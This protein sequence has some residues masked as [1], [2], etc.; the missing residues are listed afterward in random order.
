VSAISL[1]GTDFQAYNNTY[2]AATGFAGVEG[3]NGSTVYLDPQ[4]AA[5]NPLPPQSITYNV[6]V[7]NGGDVTTV[8]PA[9]T[10]NGSGSITLNYAN[11][12]VSA[13][14]INEIYD[15]SSKTYT[16]TVP[17]AT[18]SITINA[19]TI[20]SGKNTNFTDLINPDLTLAVVNN[21]NT[22]NTTLTV[23]SGSAKSTAVID[24]GSGSASW[25]P[26]LSPGNFA[27]NSGQYNTL[28]YTVEDDQGNPVPN[29]MMTIATDSGSSASSDPFFITQVNGVSL[30]QTETMGTNLSTSEP[31]PI[32]LSGAVA[33]LGYKSVTI[34]G[35]ATWNY[36]NSPNQI[37]V[38]TDSKGNVTLTLQASGTAYYAGTSGAN[39]SGPYSI[40]S[41]SP[42]S[43]SVLESVY[44]FGSKHD[45]K[46]GYTQLFIGQTS[47]DF[48]L[49][50]NVTS[51]D[52]QLY[53]T[54]SGQ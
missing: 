26:T 16:V 41:T 42:G 33:N 38:Y 30:A 19:A 36:T 53:G 25:V 22:G 51:G 28:T 8:S 31:T 39:A 3:G 11:P 50:S 18:G 37:S 43:S 54:L 24:F 10:T 20:T 46:V 6:S 13:L 34:P 44:S 2:T 14:T 21:N 29:S 35:V 1:G 12:G 17:R 7:D 5:G 45:N 23:T 40:G 4:N 15:S 52:L 48:T 9:D 27:V 49:S 32:P 47:S